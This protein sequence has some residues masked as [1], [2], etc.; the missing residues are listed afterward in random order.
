MRHLVA[1]LAE[2]QSKT[3]ALAVATVCVMLPR[4]AAAQGVLPIQW[5]YNPLAWVESVGY[6]P[7]G[8][9]LAVAGD[10][11]VQIFD[12]S[13][14]GLI[15]CLP[16][17]ANSSGQN[18]TNNAGVTSA[19]FS[20]NSQ[21]L[22]VGG[23][24][25]AGS[26]MKLIETGVVGVWNV[27]NGALIDSFDTAAN[28][29]VYS[30]AFGPNGTTLAVGGQSNHNQSPNNSYGVLELWSVTSGT[31]TKSL[32]TGAAA[33]G[34]VTTVAFSADGSTLAFGGERFRTMVPAT[35]SG[36]VEF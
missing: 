23:Q 35:K 15:R 31:L 17:A 12:A 19:S 21:M 20:S 34:C 27:S 29:G 26:G 25:Y 10:G 14:G 16:T 28:K 18:S 1:L 6:S 7:D 2:F 11:G 36:Q 4:L 9:L 30:V 22:A 3:L 8:K 33:G 32:I 5:V 24:S 13:T